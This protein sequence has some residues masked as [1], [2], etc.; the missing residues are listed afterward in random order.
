[1]FSQKCRTTLSIVVRSDL[2]QHLS[3][4]KSLYVFHN[5]SSTKHV[6]IASKFLSVLKAQ[7]PKASWVQ[8]VPQTPLPGNGCTRHPT[9][10][11]LKRSLCIFMSSWG[12]KL[13]VRSLSCVWMCHKTWALSHHCNKQRHTTALHNLCHNSETQSQ[14]A[15][16]R[17]PPLSLNRSVVC[18]RGGRE[19]SFLSYF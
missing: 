10:R 16:C 7:G 15:D 17:P 19:Y 14:G 2:T 9:A 12:K 13:N 1:M 6:L 3:E 8:Q 4:N 18:L 11:T 5:K